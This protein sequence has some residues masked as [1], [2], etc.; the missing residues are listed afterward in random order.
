MLSYVF[1]RILGKSDDSDVAKAL[2][3]LDNVVEKFGEV[4]ESNNTLMGQALQMI[5]SERSRHDQTQQKLIDTL[6]SRLAEM[7]REQ[8]LAQQEARLRVIDGPRE[9]KLIGMAA[10][11]VNEM[12]T[13]LRRSADT[14]EI[15]AS[16]GTRGPRRI[17]YL[18]KKMASEIELATVDREITAAT[19]NII[20][21]N[22]ETGWGKVRLKISE[23]PLSFNVPSDVKGIL[24]SQLVQAMG[25]NEVYLQMYVVR[26][27]AK[28]PIRVVVVGILPLP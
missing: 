24:Q 6:E 8:E 13:A 9:Q 19:G 25:R 14:L 1:E 5:E 22:K 11:L 26:D 20:Q 12:A 15:V 16:D 10:P 21:Y 23:M 28:K 18:N 7:K 27:K 17:V 3:S 4:N 2:N